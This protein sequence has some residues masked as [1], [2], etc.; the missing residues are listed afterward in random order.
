V[1]RACIMALA[2]LTILPVAVPFAMS[3]AS[4]NTVY[5][6][7]V[8]GGRGIVPTPANTPAGGTP[9]VT[10]TAVISPTETL[11]PWLTETPVPSP[12]KTTTLTPT[13]TITR[14]ATPT[15]TAT[16]TPTRTKT[17][18]P[19]PT[20]T[21]S[22]IG[23]EQAINYVGREVCVDFLVVRAH[24]SV[25]HVYLNSH[26]PYKGYFWVVLEPPYCASWQ[27]SPVAYFQGRRVRVWGR[28]QIHDGTPDIVVQPN[29]CVSVVRLN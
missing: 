14:T 2:L 11:T 5:L 29:D 12:T 21:P 3:P 7:A 9:S 16:Q 24:D 27:P 17:P 25:Q 13:V 15:W 8:I 26:D 10:F 28:I 19:I 22:C 6:P 23:P 4:A 18:T 20:D 1:R